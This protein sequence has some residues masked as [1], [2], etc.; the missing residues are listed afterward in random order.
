MVALAALVFHAPQ[1]ASDDVVE[2]AAAIT[3]CLDEDCD[4]VSSTRLANVLR[5]VDFVGRIG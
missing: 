4:M 5:G 2:Y 1:N 3:A